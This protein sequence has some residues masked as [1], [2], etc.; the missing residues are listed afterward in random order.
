M[1]FAFIIL[2]ACMFF[3][4]AAQ[5]SSTI[6]QAQ[7]FY[8]SGIFYYSNRSY[9]NAI[10]AFNN[11]N[12]LIETPVTWYFLG[13]CYF[14]RKDWGSAGDAMSKALNWRN[15]LLAAKFQT[16]AKQILQQSTDAK[17]GV[18][19]YTSNGSGE[20][21]TRRRVVPTAN[22]NI[23]GPTLMQP[24]RPLFTISNNRV[25]LP[26]M[27]VGNNNQTIGDFCCTGETAT[28]LRNDNYPVGY[29][30]FY[31]TEPATETAAAKFYI[32]VSASPSISNLAAERIKSRISFDAS[33]ELYNNATKT[34]IAGCLKFTV[35]I[36][37]VRTTG[38][39]FFDDGLRIQVDISPVQ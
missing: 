5:D 39:S 6:A 36:L 11:C 7:K 24:T 37:S 15:P 4:A 25:I 22:E 33:R 13:L 26:G 3:T 32:L 29:I 9:P 19:S 8:N 2:C 34:S 21:L 30:Y 23:F 14:N 12:N 10:K 17:N 27:G 28:I 38:R 35:T 20:A 31:G 1:K 18:Q 16:D